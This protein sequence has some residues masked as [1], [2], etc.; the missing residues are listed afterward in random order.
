M[1]AN[2]LMEMDTEIKDQPLSITV[3]IS[4]HSDIKIRCVKK[5]NVFVCVGVCG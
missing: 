1:T 4:V 3:R 2:R 5:E